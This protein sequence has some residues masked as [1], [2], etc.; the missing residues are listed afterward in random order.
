MTNDSSVTVDRD[1]T[2]THHATWWLP[3]HD[4]GQWLANTKITM[5]IKNTA[6]T[7]GQAKARPNVR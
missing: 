7:R 1:A 6:V 5:S 4:S 3:C 2:P